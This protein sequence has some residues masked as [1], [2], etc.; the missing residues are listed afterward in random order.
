MQKS[1]HRV[2]RRENTSKNNI[3]KIHNTLYYKTIH[4]IVQLLKNFLIVI[5]IFCYGQDIK[6][7]KSFKCHILE[8][9]FL[10]T[11]NRKLFTKKKT[12]KYR[13]L[14]T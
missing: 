3:V 7:I 1:K 4:T 10:N 5:R 14:L 2:N 12:H 9:V 11:F 6:I 8:K 13:K